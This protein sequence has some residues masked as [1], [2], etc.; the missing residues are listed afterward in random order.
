MSGRVLSCLIFLSVVTTTPARSAEAPSEYQLKSAFVY[1]FATFI[2]WPAD[3]GKDLV[4]CVAAPQSALEYFLQ[5]NGKPVG[6][7]NLVVRPLARA[8]SPVSCH[9][10]YVANS[11]DAAFDAW[12]PE[13]EGRKTLTVGESQMW[14]KRGVMIELAVEGAK[15]AFDVNAEA[16]RKAGLNINSKLL[17]LARMVYGAAGDDE[18]AR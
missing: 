13:L 5:L 14:L 6:S 11:E 4:L 1:N 2:D 3:I 10:L 17:R 8:A 16:A 15:V 9:I 7:V 18:S 12:L